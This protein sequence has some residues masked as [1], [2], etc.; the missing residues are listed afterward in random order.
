MG[1]TYLYQ[2]SIQVDSYD[3]AVELLRKKVKNRLYRGWINHKD[4]S[5]VTTV[6]RS[7]TAVVNVKDFIIDTEAFSHYLETARYAELYP[8]Y[9]PG[10]IVEKSLEHFISLHLLR[11]TAGDVFVDIASEGS[12]LPDIVS[13]LYGSTCYAQDIMYPPGINGKWIGGD[14]CA[15]PVSDASISKATLTCSLEHFEGDSDTRLF[16]ELARVLQSGGQVVVVPLYMFTDAIT[17]T[18]PRYSAAVNVTFDPDTAIYCAD[19]WCNRHGRF[20]SADTLTHRVLKAT[21]QLRFTAYR[22]IGAE[23]I[24]GSTYATFALLAQKV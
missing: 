13:R 24:S 3:V 21:T 9:Y 18:D 12:P 2:P 4:A 16:R 11:P 15:M 5:V 8:Q 1:E 7:L 22:I 20:Y 10:N 19:G 23:N 17:L 6:T 14:A